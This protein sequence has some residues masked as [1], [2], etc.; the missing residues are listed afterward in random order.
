MDNFVFPLLS[1]KLVK[2]DDDCM[3]WFCPGCDMLHP[4]YLARDPS[5]KNQ[6]IWRFDGNLECPTFTPS[7]VT[8]LSDVKKCHVF[9][10]Q[11][12]IQ[13]LDDCWHHLRSTTIDL[14]DVPE[15]AH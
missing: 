1:K 13:Y 9:V 4:V 12:K 6:S 3:A 8:K 15:D 11:G 14:P 10:I 2:I 7:V 5:D